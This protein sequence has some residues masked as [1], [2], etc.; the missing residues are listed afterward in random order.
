MKNFYMPLLLLGFLAFAPQVAK[1]D[2]RSPAGETKWMKDKI[3][4]MADKGYYPYKGGFIS[5][6]G[7]IKNFQNTKYRADILL[8]FYKKKL[9]LMQDYQNNNLE[10]K[11]IPEG[12]TRMN[13]SFFYNFAYYVDPS[14]ETEVKKIQGI[15]Y[16]PLGAVHHGSVL[17]DCNEYITMGNL[18]YDVTGVPP[19][20]Y[21]KYIPETQEMQVL[22]PKDYVY[23]QRY[24]SRY[25]DI[26]PEEPFAIQF[27]NNKIQ[28]ISSAI[29]DLQQSIDADKDIKLMAQKLEELENTI[30]KTEVSVSLF[31]TL[32]TNEFEQP[33]VKQGQ[34][35]TNTNFEEQIDS[36]SI[37][38]F[39]IRGMLIA[40]LLTIIIEGIIAL[41]FGWKFV[42]LVTLAN[43]IT[44]PALNG[45]IWHYQIISTQTILLLEA[46]V[47]LV[48]WGI[49]SVFIRQKYL[50]LFLFALVANA[51]SYLSG[52]LIF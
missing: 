14:G 46:A 26:L 6:E 40:L 4:E 30:R 12:V 37:P 45:I 32:G 41:P 48:E 28:R 35:D 20:S 49:F 22:V 13:N 9:G 34:D 23:R 47:V 44:N 17:I 24:Q 38:D 33:E 29:N 31:N 21:L 42:G 51:V 5:K 16:K 52:L 10:L 1:A 36:D 15:E 3:K 19:Q 8:C 11:E 50:K 2:L 43:I 25:K 7:I 39:V 18:G 27:L